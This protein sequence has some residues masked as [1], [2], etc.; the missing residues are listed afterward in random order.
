MNKNV[1]VRV[2]G[3]GLR[4]FFDRGRNTLANWIVAKGSHLKLPFH[5]K[6]RAT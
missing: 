5:L 1:K 2:T 3:D 6:T 4:E